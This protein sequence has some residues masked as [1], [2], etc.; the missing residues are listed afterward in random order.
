MQDRTSANSEQS[1][2]NAR[3]D[4]TFGSSAVEM[5]SVTLP[6]MSAPPRKRTS[7][8]TSWDVRLV[9]FA[10]LCAATNEVRGYSITSSVR[11]SS[12]IGGSRPSA[13]A[14]LRLMTSLELGGLL[15]RQIAA[16]SS[17]R[18]RST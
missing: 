6:F 2:C 15:D 3:R 10:T 5:L 11:A 1:S 14:V 17:L 8:Q 13:L 7:G 12:D 4:H 18:M 16:F 9:P